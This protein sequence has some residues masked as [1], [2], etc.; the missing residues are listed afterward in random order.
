MS[1]VTDGFGSLAPT[2]VVDGF[3]STGVVLNPAPVRSREP[4]TPLGIAERRQWAL[5]SD[6]DLFLTSAGDVSVIDGSAQVAQD[7]KQRLEFY[8]GEW[9]LA[10]DDGTDWIG[11][12]LKKNP[13]LRAVDSLIKKRIIETSGVT[14]LLDYVRTFNASTRTLGISFKYHDQYTDAVQAL[15]LTEIGS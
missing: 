1:L 15:T 10:L 3:L 12:V 9:F 6:G 4:I 8:L 5:D 7:L 14:E 13:V 11:I 2:L